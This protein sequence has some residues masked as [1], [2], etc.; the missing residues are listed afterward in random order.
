MKYI[1]KKTII[2]ISL[3]FF[4]GCEKT[5]D[6]SNLK[7]V[8]GV[9]V[10]NSNSK[11]YTGRIEGL[12]KGIYT[13]GQMKNGLAEGE[14]Y[15]YHGNGELDRVGHFYLGKRTGDWY[16]YDNEANHLKTETLENGELINTDNIK[17]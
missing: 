1:Y 8:N 13:K 16:F 5:S 15:F 10:L 11:P 17:E 3:I 7:E 14:W 6:M 12:V 4:L 2:I 9:Y